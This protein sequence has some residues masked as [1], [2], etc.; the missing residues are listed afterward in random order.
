MRPLLRPLGATL[1]LLL[2]ACGGGAEGPQEGRTQPPAAR[3]VQPPS[4]EEAGID[5]REG[6]QGTCRTGSVV[7]TVV[8]RRRPLTF[9]GEMSVRLADV[10]RR[11]R[12]LTVALRVTN[13]GSEP[14]D[15]TADRQ[16]VALWAADRLRAP[17]EPGG[18]E[19]AIPPGESRVVRVAWRLPA[20]ASADDRGTAVVV[21]PPSEHEAG[22]VSPQDAQRIGVLRLWK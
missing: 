1:A 20:G 17:I 22:A 12:R 8:D 6:R 21:V 18:G 3:A 7:R 16:R 4:C 10:R 19:A 9:D 11:D 5:E 2:A 14:L 15:W 13:R